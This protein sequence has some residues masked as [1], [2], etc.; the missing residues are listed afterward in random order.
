MVFPTVEGG[1]GHAVDLVR[2]IRSEYGDYFGIGVAG[3]QRGSPL[4]L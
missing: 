3:S 2:Y 1:F 4:P